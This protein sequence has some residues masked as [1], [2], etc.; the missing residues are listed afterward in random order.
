MYRVSYLAGVAL[1]VATFGCKDEATSPTPPAALPSP[2][3]SISTAAPLVFRQVS[4]GGIHSC[5]VT[6]DNRAY[7]WGWNYF[8]QL[9]TGSN[10][11][12]EQC[13]GAGG[14]FPCSTRPALV[15]GG[16]SF[17]QVSVGRNHTCGV[18]TED[19]AYCWGENSGSLG[20]GSTVNRSSPV[21]VAGGREFRQ[22]E[23]G[24]FHSCGV[25]RGN[26]A[27]CWGSNTYGQLGD[28]T[29]STRLKPVAVVGGLTFK[30]VSTGIGS[31]EFT[32]G[33]TTENRAYC[34]G[35]NRSGQVG[36]SSTATRRVRP[37]PVA[38]NRQFRQVD[39][40]D[41]H[42]CGVTTANK[43][44][45]W[46]DGRGGELGNGKS[47][48]SFW[49]RA[50]AGGLA[51]QRV[52]AG[53]T[54][55]CGIATTGGRAYCWGSNNSGQ[56]GDGTTTP[57]LTPVAVAGGVEFLQ[58]GPGGLHTCGTS[59]AGQGYCWG[60]GFFGQLGNGTSSSGAGAQTPSAVAGPM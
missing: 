17:R 31:Q 42:A 49:P 39:A 57:R 41:A 48:L 55:S 46:G 13:Q 2:E 24:Y 15:A 60:D 14:P 34:W 16:H 1:L 58:I 23:A 52:S 21:P 4:A 32:C 6:T 47:Y 35:N 22:V 5:G 54:Q 18:T 51:F 56:V 30:H 38:G 53:E 29:T 44:F 20:D 9:G 36:D 12:P 40:G 37:V 25:T 28:G 59:S 19:Q 10:T 33:V 43:A 8:G 3:M 26:R 11:G 45:C 27:F 50:V 7:C